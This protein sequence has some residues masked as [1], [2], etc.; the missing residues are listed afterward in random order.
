MGIH[1]KIYD[2][3]VI[4]IGAGVGG[5]VCGCYLAK[6]GM[7]VLIVEK[8][9]KVGGYCTSFERD[10]FLFDACAHSLGSCRKEGNITKMF[11]ELGIKH[12]ISVKRHDPSDIIITPHHKISFRSDLNKTIAEFSRYFPRE[13][14]NIKRFFN[15]TAKLSDL[16]LLALRNK[17][18][19]QVL[20]ENFTDS[21]LKAILSFPVLG[22]SGVNPSE[23]SAFSSLM[24]YREFMLDGGYYPENSIQDLPDILMSRLKELGGEIKLSSIV[25]K[26][27]IEKK[28]AR[29]VLLEGQGAFSAKHIV[30]ACDAFQTFTKLIGASILSGSFIKQ[31]SRMKTSLSM[32]ILYI[33]IDNRLEID[34]PEYANVWCLPHFNMKK[35]YLGA[36]KRTAKNLSEFMIRVLP[37]RKSFVVFANAGFGN[38][39]YWEDERNQKQVIN[40]FICKIDKLI[41]DF[42]SHVVFR[43]IATP[44]T[45]YNWTLNYRGASYGW[46]S[47]PSQIMLPGFVI[48][49]QLS[50]LYLS[51][52][53]STVA[54][55]IRGVM[56]LGIS[57]AKNIYNKNLNV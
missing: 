10:G 53:W 13:K 1:K 37:G 26:I 3:D 46:A 43:E 12:R 19:G 34:L 45:L 50:N 33:G 54:Y 11:E 36:S 16:S 4:I 57:T 17:T 38:K 15:S 6:A 39:N 42:S 14:E 18:F 27:V 7:K 44:R 40:T 49:N 22:N 52:H 23:A 48:S 5:L 21:R 20:N 47:L 9:A 41:P 31:L 8:N 24:L 2:Y 55:S 30:S 51:G 29:G 32:L 25:K 56:Y 28:S 35:L